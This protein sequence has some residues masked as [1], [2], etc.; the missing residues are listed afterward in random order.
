MTNSNII[1]LIGLMGSGKTSIGKLLAKETAREFVDTDHEIIKEKNLTIDNIFK[2]FGEN[3]FRDIEHNTLLKLIKN[4]NSIISTGGGIILKKE[5]VDI[6]INSGKIIF[7]DIDIKTQIL[8]IKNKKNRP[9]LDNDHM[10]EDLKKMKESRDRIYNSI[11]NY[12]VNVS[13]KTK[14]EILTELKNKLK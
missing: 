6:M 7:L 12:I 9:L 11:A 2:K 4:K 10:E 1:F 3:Y 8:R 5:N 14:I 13:S